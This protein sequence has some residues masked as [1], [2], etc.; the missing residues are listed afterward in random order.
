MIDIFDNK[1]LDLNN[2][3]EKYKKL[4]IEVECI[5]TDEVIYSFLD[6]S[7]I[8]EIINTL[9]N[10]MFKYRIFKVE[11]CEDFR[12]NHFYD[13]QGNYLHKELLGCN[14]NKFFLFLKKYIFNEPYDVRD[15]YFRVDGS[16]AVW[17]IEGLKLEV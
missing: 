13:I 7:D 12:I 5:K 10:D 4:K 3:I 16:L 6:Y 17:N 8:S 2:I 1:P 9:D 11:R 14:G 15:L